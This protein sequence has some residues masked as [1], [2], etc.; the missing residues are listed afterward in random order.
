[1]RRFIQTQTKQGD[2]HSDKTLSRARDSHVR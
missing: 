2:K 1:M